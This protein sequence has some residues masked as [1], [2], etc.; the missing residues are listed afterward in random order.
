M[1]KCFRSSGSSQPASILAHATR[2][3]SRVKWG[4]T[5]HLFDNPSEAPHWTSMAYQEAFGA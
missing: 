5:V 2:V 3:A 1:V 4:A